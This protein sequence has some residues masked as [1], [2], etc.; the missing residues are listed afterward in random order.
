[1]IVRA[2]IPDYMGALAPLDNVGSMRNQGFEI[3]VN[4]NNEIGKVK[5]NVGLNLSLLQTKLLV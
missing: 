4:H 5:Y 3:T 2:P 1:M